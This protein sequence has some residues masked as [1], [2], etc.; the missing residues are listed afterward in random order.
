MADY[1]THFIEEAREQLSEMSSALLDLEDDPSNDD[2]MD[3]IFRAAHTLKG[4]AG[5]M[6]YNDMSALAHAV[7]D[8][9]DGIRQDSIEV[10]SDLIDVLFAGLDLLEQHVDEI[11]SNG[12]T[13][14]DP[15]EVVTALRKRVPDD[16]ERSA[17]TEVRNTADD[18]EVGEDGTA[19]DCIQ[20]K[21]DGERCQNTAQD[22]S[23]FCYA[24]PLDEPSSEDESD[25]GDDANA[26]LPNVGF[27]SDED[28][29][30]LI[31]RVDSDKLAAQPFFVRVQAAGNV[32][33]LIRQGEF[34]PLEA[35][36]DAFTVVITDPPKEELQDAESYLSGMAFDTV[37]D[38]TIGA[39]R[40]STAMDGVATVATLHV[41]SLEDALPEDT[42]D[43]N[44]ADAVEGEFDD[45]SIDELLD[46]LTEFDDI[47]SIDPDMIDDVE[48]GE[49]GEGG[50]FDNTE[51]GEAVDE[52][53]A[54]LSDD[55]GE[56][57]EDGIEA[58]EAGETGNDGVDMFDEL[59][60]EVEEETGGGPVEYA[61]IE[62][63]M[64]EIGFDEL[65]TD[66]E[67]E[68]EALVGGETTEN[69]FEFGDEEEEVE[70]DAGGE[71]E[72]E[73]GD[74]PVDAEVDS[75]DEPET[76]EKPE[77]IS[78]GGDD[79]PDTAS[80]S[81]GGAE[82]S[83]ESYG[84]GSGESAEDV[85]S[86]GF[87][88]DVDEATAE[89]DAEADASADVSG[90]DVD[91]ALA[92]AEEDFGS[93]ADGEDFTEE[94]DTFGSAF[95]A[96]EDATDFDDLLVDAGRDPV[97]GDGSEIK[98]IR[99]DV[100]RLDELYSQMQELITNR[101]RLRRA[102]EGART[103]DTSL[104]QALDDL[105]SLEKVSS[106]MQDTI[107][108]IR[109]VPL[110]QATER[111]P[112][113]ARDVSR[114]QGKDVEFEMEGT[115]VELDRA[116]LGEI[117]DPLMHIVRNAVS[118]GIESPDERE[119]SGKSREGHVTLT[120]ERQRD[121]VEVTVSDDG[122]GM[123]A[124]ALRQEAV[125]D[126]LL[127][128]EEAGQITDEQ[129]CELAFRPGFS[130]AQE[131]TET[132]GRG[133]GMDVVYD[134]VRSLDGSVSIESE[135][136]EGTTIRLRLPVS[137]AIEDMLFVRVGGEEYGLPIKNVDEISYV[138]NI[139]SVEG[140]D[141]HVHE[142]EVYPLVRLGE[143]L[144][145]GSDTDGY[146]GRLVRIRDDV[147]QIALHCDAVVG[148]E[149]VVVEPFDGVLNSIPGLSGATVLG[150]G[151]VINILDV[152]TL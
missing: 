8:V 69:D 59:Q 24:H 17:E 150:E 119:A 103:Q 36:E 20:I 118:H 143:A 63:E 101:I 19:T 80:A 89:A 75:P 46:D 125:E 49:L 79:E 72:V 30:S 33:E 147:R 76:A 39:D 105:D 1:N 133:V 86:E 100:S 37:V 107:M 99:V 61:E 27:P 53:S 134:T 146:N 35:L 78:L 141:T 145:G 152:E 11:A 6:E 90:V 48:L 34:T 108:N 151:N 4:N 5:A 10:S 42:L 95:D 64:E 43:E 148:Q 70:A 98:S 31:E 38:S 44:M 114:E 57:E 51:V 60:S 112:R 92:G 55:D 2:A 21:D 106:R 14:S 56:E 73:A 54:S 102:I 91:E 96:D 130:T 84:T 47:D 68:F 93:A 58:V 128:E 66:D 45:V 50:T 9:L 140:E 29:L 117:G 121:R 81:S 15:G 144:E 16:M 124:D 65:D 142:D 74:E 110:S 82:A 129:A 26:D 62:K 83:S 3:S 104:A 115:E 22:G 28:V 41:Q 97:G 109:L 18:Y 94:F 135:P 131:V 116:V 87:S 32:T 67:I 40:I 77:G 120:A 85:F 71:P 136:G 123:D 138:S 113:I 111:L 122:R 132:S 23:N 126:G 139:E 88:P 52:G 25:A 149:E 127:S 137:L 7:E 13:E 12:E